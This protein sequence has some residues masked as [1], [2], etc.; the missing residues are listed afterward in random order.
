MNQKFFVTCAAAALLL[1]AAV[2]CACGRAAGG[3]EAAQF[4]EPDSAS[5]S[6]SAEATG[7]ETT[8]APLLMK[9]EPAYGL[10]LSALCAFR[11]G[12]HTVFTPEGAREYFDKTFGPAYGSMEDRTVSAF[13]DNGHAMVL[14]LDDVGAGVNYYKLYFTEDFGNTWTENTYGS[15]AT[16]GSRAIVTD[17]NDYWMYGFSDPYEDSYLL[18]LTVS[19]P[20][21]RD[22]VYLFDSAFSRD[23]ARGY[24]HIT[25]IYFDPDARLL[26]VN[27]EFWDTLSASSDHT[28]FASYRLEFEKDLTLVSKEKTG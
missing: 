18:Y 8:T 9:P 1:I 26:R 2:L 6:R 23:A 15:S 17:G 27:A 19:A 16:H 28:V 10:M 3:N 5:L 21:R 14:F 22:K 20:E 12:Y 24:P 4:V 13:S 11:D 25:D 7:E